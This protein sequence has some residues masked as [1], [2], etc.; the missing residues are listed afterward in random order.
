MKLCTILADSMSPQQVDAI[1]VY[2]GLVHAAM[3]IFFVGAA[4]IAFIYCW[5][6]GRLGLDE[7]ASIQM[8]HDEGHKSETRQ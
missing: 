3:V 1:G 6:T 2:G 8:M 4:L 5:K 7:D